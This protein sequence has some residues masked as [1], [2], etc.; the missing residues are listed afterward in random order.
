MSEQRTAYYY[1]VYLNTDSSGNPILDENGD[2]TF[3]FVPSHSA[4]DPTYSYFRDEE[5]GC[6]VTHEIS[7]SN[8]LST[9]YMSNYDDSTGIYSPLSYEEVARNPWDYFRSSDLVEDEAGVLHLDLEKADFLVDCYGGSAVN[10]VSDAT[11]TLNEDNE[12]TA[13][14]LT[15]PDIGEEGRY[16][17]VTSMRI[18]YSEHGIDQVE[19]VAPYTN[20]NPDLEVALSCLDNQTNFKYR[21]DMVASDSSTGAIQTSATIGYYNELL[22]YYHHLYENTEESDEINQAM[23]EADDDY[24]YMV[25]YDDE[26][27]IYYAYSYEFAG[28]DWSWGIVSLSG[29]QP[30]TFNS[31]SEIGPRFGEVSS[32][33]FKKTGDLTYEAE[34]GVLAGVGT[35]FDNQFAGVHSEALNGGTTKCVLTLNAAKT[36]IEKVEMA[37]NFGTWT[38]SVNFTL[39]NI[40]TTTIPSY[41]VY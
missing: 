28:M 14:V 31:F 13:L 32:K 39:S 15:T 33:V 4:D 26:E 8:E 30:Y 7:V 16:R 40:G 24:D 12:V 18:D 25:R 19:D 23:Y 20:D 29:T 35:Y 21:R 17:R 5:T 41:L 10:W 27:K 37:F 36:A 9:T 3:S 22:V 34:R 38:Y 6:A 2:Y 11:I 1:D